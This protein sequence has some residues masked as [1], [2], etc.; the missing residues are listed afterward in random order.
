[1]GADDW[2]HLRGGH[3]QRRDVKAGFRLGFFAGFPDAFD[4]D[5]ALQAR[6]VMAVAEPF[7]I[8]DDRCRP[9]F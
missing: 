1:M 7:G 9:G 5:D 2:S 3:D 8:V 4:H 6:P